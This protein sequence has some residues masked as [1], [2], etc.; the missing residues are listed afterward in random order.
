MRLGEAGNE[1][2]EAGSEGGG[3]GS[4]G[5]YMHPIILK[6]YSACAFCTALVQLTRVTCCGRLGLLGPIPA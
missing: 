4:H 1:A 5:L 3:T 6:S 2:G